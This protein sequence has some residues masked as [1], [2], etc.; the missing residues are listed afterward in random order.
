MRAM[1]F[2]SIP[3][4][5]ST[6]NA[7]KEAGA[8][9]AR[10]DRS[11]G[12]VL[13]ITPEDKPVINLGASSFVSDDERVWNSGN[14]IHTLMTPERTRMRF[15]GFMP[16]ATWVGPGFYWS[17]TPGYGGRGKQRLYIGRRED[18]IVE[19]REASWNRG[20]VQVE[21]EGQEYR[22]ITVS[23]KVVQSSQ[24]FGSNGNRR[25]EWVGL[26]GTPAHVKE[27]AR[28]CART[29]DS[30]RTVVGWD[31]VDTGTEAFMFEGNSCPGVN[32]ATADRILT[33]VERYYE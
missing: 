1:M 8:M 11:P 10:R 25:Y 6:R 19:Q 9:F 26:Q 7:W 32:A 21:V 31:I 28:Q 13:N 5:L 18:W 17:K 30:M 24:R 2:R 23:D 33:Q 20:E 14:H 22:V 12:S 29:L 16:T 3:L 4:A 27:L 15:A